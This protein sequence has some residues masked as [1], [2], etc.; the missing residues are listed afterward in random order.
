MIKFFK[1]LLSKEDKISTKDEAIIAKSKLDSLKLKKDLKELRRTVSN[2][3]K[4]YFPFTI[5]TYY[6]QP[7]TIAIVIAELHEAGWRVNT[8]N[9]FVLEVS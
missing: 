2:R 6:Y 4:T 9:P 3:T 1:K 5:Y 7:E 8:G